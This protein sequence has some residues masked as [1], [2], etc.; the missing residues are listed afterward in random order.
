MGSV[1]HLG[2]TKAL[3]AALAGLLHLGLQ[4]DQAEDGWLPVAV[5]WYSLLR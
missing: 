4:Y 3:D 1:R 2:S 5:P